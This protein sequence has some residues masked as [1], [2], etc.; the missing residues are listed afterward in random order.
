MHRLP[1]TPDASRLYPRISEVLRTLV[2]GLEGETVAVGT[3]FD[4][5]GTRAFGFLIL[6]D[7]LPM[8]IPNVPGVST[9]FGLLIMAPALQIAIGGTRVWLPERW[10]RR[11]IPTRT[12]AVIVARTL[13]TIERAER[14]VRPRWVVLTLPPARNVIGVL[15]LALGFVMFLPIPGGNMPPGVACA[16]ISIGVLERDGV[17]IAIGTAVGLVALAIA[18]GVVYGVVYLGT[19][20]TG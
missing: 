11:T 20:I 8:V 19:A 14:L 15:M 12:I 2:A 13:P 5:L 10:R 16:L 7:S 6:L 17:F 9:V 18:G 1:P 3:I 4:R